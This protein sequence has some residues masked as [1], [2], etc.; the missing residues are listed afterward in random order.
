MH[1]PASHLLRKP[2]GLHSQ[3]VLISTCDA[4]RVNNQCV[5]KPNITNY[6]HVD[7]GGLD[8]VSNNLDCVSHGLGLGLF[9]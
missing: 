9:F 8:R 7:T 6:A 1:V 2:S 4:K 3:E 5:H